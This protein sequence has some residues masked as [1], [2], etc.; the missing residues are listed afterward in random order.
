MELYSPVGMNQRA[1]VEAS[2]MERILRDN[3]LGAILISRGL[4]SEEQLGLGLQVQ[5]R[6]GGWRKLGDV[7]LDLGYLSAE[8]LN[9]ALEVQKRMAE[10]VLARL[11]GPRPLVPR[12]EPGR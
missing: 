6:E 8:G 7:L 11:E 1:H 3:L 9:E 2:S 4:L 5:E 10:E 12:P